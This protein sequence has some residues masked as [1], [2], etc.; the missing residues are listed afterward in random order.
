MTLLGIDLGGSHAT[1][2]LVRGESVLLS[3]HLNL[4]DCSRF[5]A[6][7]PYICACLRKLAGDSPEP[8]EGLGIGFPGLADF[9]TNR[10]LSTNGKYEDAP[11]FDFDAWAWKNLG[12]PAQLENDA[13]L[14]LRG[15][16]HSGA[17]RGFTDVVMFTLGTGIGGVAAMNG[18]P[19]YGRHGHAGVLC[20]HVPV[21][22]NGHPCT[23]GGRGCAE[24]E[25]AGW[26]LPIIAREWPGFAQSALAQHPISFKALF[27]CC[28]DGDEVALALRDHCLNI[29]AMTTVA[30]VHAFDPEVV[31]FG[32]GVMGASAEILPFINNYVQKHTWTSWG[33]PP[34]VSATLGSQAAALGV[35]TL[36]WRERT[37]V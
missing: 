21:R 28:K 5:A 20:G 30:A 31:I 24:A 15:E 34:V 14:A 25:A 35:P 23:C 1:C 18:E 36:F 2:S 17:G 4:P 37:H 11:D 33:K 29:W 12:I 6:V 9:R 10:V 27:A 26:S 32:G 13:R 3:E 16:M 19:L 8:V 22:E 7:A